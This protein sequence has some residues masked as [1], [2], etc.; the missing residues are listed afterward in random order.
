[1][2][3][4]LPALPIPIVYCKI[5]GRDIFEVNPNWV[6]ASANHNQL[7]A[8][9]IRDYKRS[10]TVLNTKGIMVRKP[11]PAWAREGRCPTEYCFGTWWKEDERRLVIKVPK[12]LIAAQEEHKQ[13]AVNA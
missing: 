6:K 7:R 1:M 4:Q 3:D 5:C 10:L 8:K 9:I 11:L 12:T 2:Q 13:N